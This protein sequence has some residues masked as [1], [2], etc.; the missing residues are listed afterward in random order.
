[1]VD[2]V[3]IIDCSM[4]LK[5]FIDQKWIFFVGQKNIYFFE[6]FQKVIEL[7]LKNFLTD[8]D[9][10][11]IFTF[12]TTNE[13]FIFVKNKLLIVETEYYEVSQW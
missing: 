7:N 2:V 10:S 8:K 13:I 11:Q 12:Y 6:D 5:V 4:F 1:M 3:E 9:E